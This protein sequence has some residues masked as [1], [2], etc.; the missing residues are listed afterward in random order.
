MRKIELRKK[1]LSSKGQVTD[2]RAERLQ[3]A[4]THAW[5]L[6]LAKKFQARFQRILGASSL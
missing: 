3:Q 4:S 1:M 2:I 6:K 5:T